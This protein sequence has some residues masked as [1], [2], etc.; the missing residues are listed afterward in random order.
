MRIKA[1]HMA[2]RTV[3]RSPPPAI[4][5]KSNLTVA[6]QTLLTTETAANLAAK[7]ARIDMKEAAYLRRLIR[8]DLGEISAEETP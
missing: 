8:I 5:P 7:L 2:R 4:S 6:V 1:N 3:K